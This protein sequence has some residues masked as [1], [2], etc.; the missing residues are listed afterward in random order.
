MSTGFYSIPEQIILVLCSAISGSLSLLGSSI[1]LWIIWRDRS[2]KLKHFYHR[3]LFVIS[4][5]DC[6]TSIN[7]I[8]SFLAVPDGLFWGAMGNTTTCEASGF[9]ISFLSSIG[10]YNAGLAL[11]YFLII[12]RS[13]PQDILTRKLE[14]L[15]HIISILLPISFCTWILITD[16][17]NPLLYNG[18]WCSVYKFPQ[19]CSSHGSDVECTRG[20]MSKLVATFFM[21]CLNLPPFL[22]FILAMASIIWFTKKQSMTVSRFRVASRF[23]YFNETINQALLYILSFLI[24]YS[25][26]LTIRFLVACLF[27]LI[28]PLSGFSNFIIYIFD[29]DIFCYGWIVE[30]VHLRILFFKQSS[31]EADQM[32]QQLRLMM[33]LPQS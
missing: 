16:S 1:I 21:L 31:L 15:T 13:L 29:Q 19:G 10:F 4:I 18:G 27:K 24:P 26:A 2:I 8:F 22:I 5:I 17:Y 28:L 32:S 14:A 7:F 3:I 33:S 23:D 6:A 9:I 30:R 20:K 12:V 25:I 11:Y